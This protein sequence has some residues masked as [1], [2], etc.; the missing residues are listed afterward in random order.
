MPRYKLV[1]LTSAVEGRDEEFN[2]WYQN[3]HLRDVVDIPGVTSARRFRMTMPL[4]ETADGPKPFP[5]LA[6]YEVETDDIKSVIDDLNSRAGTER[7]TLSERLGEKLY[8]VVYED[9]GAVVSR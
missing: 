2:D 5:Y 8:A 3:T 1:V 6:I 9:F 7:M 4:K